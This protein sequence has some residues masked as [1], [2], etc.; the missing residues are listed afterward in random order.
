M[1]YETIANIPMMSSSPEERLLY[2]QLEASAKKKR[3]LALM[4][5]DYRKNPS[6]YGPD[7]RLF[8]EQQAMEAGLPMPD[9][10][11]NPLKAVA[12]GGAAAL[13]TAL[14]GLLPN[15]LYTPL[16][17]AER[18]A[19]GIGGVAGAFV[20]GPAALGRLALRGVS[21]LPRIMRGGLMQGMGQSGYRNLAQ[22]G[23]LLNMLGGRGGR[24]NFMSRERIPTVTGE[25]V[26]PG[27]ALAGTR[28]AATM[29]QRAIPALKASEV[30]LLNKMRS[31][32]DLRASELEQLS[33]STNPLMQQ[34]FNQIR[35]PQTRG[36]L[37]G[38]LGQAT[39]GGRMLP[40]AGQQVSLF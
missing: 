24:N 37:G 5:K 17:Q 14:F 28:A 10:K 11:I 30:K 13:D 22:R 19:T 27:A 25:V 36:Q 15:E 32:V 31:G 2:K 12:K 35:F 29:G 6:K 34:L 20:G 26:N 8:L 39:S 16:N 33:K 38:L 40:A 7:Q 4:L 23:G 3:N 18:I 9:T 1:A 21:G